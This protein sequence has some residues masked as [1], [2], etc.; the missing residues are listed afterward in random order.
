MFWAGAGAVALLV[1]LSAAAPLISSY[2]P[3]DADPTA[4]LEPPSARHWAGTDQLGRDL[5][6]RIAWG[7]RASLSVAFGIVGIGVGLG[8]VTGAAIALAGRWADLVAMRILDVLVSVP[9]MVIA[10]ALSAALGPGLGKLL[11]VLGLLDAPYFARLF[12]GETLSIRE[13]PYIAAAR[14]S[15]AGFWRILLRHVLPNLAPV[16]ATFASNALGRALVAASAL[17]FIG[18]GAQP[19]TP[20][21]GVL[22]YEGR[23]T[24]MFEWWCSVLPGLMVF[25]AALGFVMAGD[26]LRDWLDPRS[27]RP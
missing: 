3:L 15:G 8:L 22:I 24:L 16:V 10:V 17:S 25:I 4:I 26:G 27:S 19:P 20:E 6:A 21:W 11:L 18:L 12:R 5:F 1:L 7:G 13:Q 9:G 23:N 14:A 2:S